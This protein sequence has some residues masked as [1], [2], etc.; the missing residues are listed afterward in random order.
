MK[1][2]LSELH[3]RG[4]DVQ[5][6]GWTNNFI[7]FLIDSLWREP[8]Y[9]GMTGFL[10]PDNINVS[11]SYANRNITLTGDL[12]YVWMGTVKKLNSPWV[13]TAHADTLGKKFLFSIDGINFEWYNTVWSFADCMIVMVNRKA[14]AAETFAIRECHGTMDKD[15]HEGQHETQ[16]TYLDPVNGG[17]KATSATYTINSASNADTTPG[18]DQAII[19]DEDLS[20]TIPA[21]PQGT[22]T[23][24]KIASGQVAEFNTVASYPFTETGSYL[25]VNN[26]ATGAMENG[27]NNRFYN[28]YQCLIP[29][30]SDI[31]S[32]KYRM[33][34]I[35]PQAT[36]TTQPQAEAEN[37]DALNFGD[38]ATLSAEFK[39]YAR[40]TYGTG[41]G[42]SNA[43]KC[44]LIN[45]TYVAGTKGNPVN[46]S[47]YVPQILADPPQEFEFADVV[48]GTAK[49]YTLII[50][51]KFRFIILGVCLET[52]N[53][54]LTGVAVKINSTAVTS[55]SSITVDTAVDETDA[56]GANIVEIGD[57]VYLSVSTGYTGTPTLIRGSLFTIRL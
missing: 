12:R 13:S 42:N 55:L 27:I 37:T 38:L 57:R 39:V 49:D 31:G 46:I 2:T 14:S 33:V 21:W 35:Q 32:Q 24:M 8:V 52:N 45:I 26:P 15:A 54:T 34:M 40:L 1:G 5:R 51:A 6:K 56:T 53:G 28:V 50:K 20:T 47:G 44:K 4:N 17:G 23:T 16:G 43:G 18:F 19:K 22:Y 29:V 41:A 11:Y 36:Y 9:Q 3:R 30:T 25:Q 10:S 7:H 48:A